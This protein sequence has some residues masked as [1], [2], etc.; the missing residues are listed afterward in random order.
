MIDILDASYFEGIENDWKV[1]GTGKI[2]ITSTSGQNGTDE[3]GNSSA[4]FT[5]DKSTASETVSCSYEFP[6]GST[7]KLSQEATNGTSF[8]EWGT[9]KA[10]SSANNMD[11]TMDGNKNI[12]AKFNDKYNDPYYLNMNVTGV[13]DVN[14]TSYN[15]SNSATNGVKLDADGDTIETANKFTCAVSA[16]VSDDYPTS[17]CSYQYAY[18]DILYISPSAGTDYYFPNSDYDGAYWNSGDYGS[19][20]TTDNVSYSYGKGTCKLVMNSSLI[21]DSS[22]TRTADIYFGKITGEIPD[23]TDPPS[24]INNNLI[25]NILDLYDSNTDVDKFIDGTGKVVVSLISNGSGTDENGNSGT[26]FTCEKTGD[27]STSCSYSFPEG[28]Q[29]T[30]KQQATKGD[31]V[32]W[33]T[34]DTDIS[35]C[36]K[37]TSTGSGDK[38]VLLGTDKYITASFNDKTN[39]YYN[40][41]VDILDATDITGTANDKYVDGTGSISV[42]SDQKRDG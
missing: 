6:D 1:D 37:D 3:E 24:T 39:D 22:T 13:G 33:A 9:G 32:S 40:L 36:N 8:I 28:S 10:T 31:F 23:P 34:C 11:L 20:C 30:L 25:I 42:S 18:G 16:D 15:S 14:I 35:N 2:I 19:G 17:L 7:I 27:Y 41:T 4:S 21:D 26:T 5:C 29:I 38:T 12:T